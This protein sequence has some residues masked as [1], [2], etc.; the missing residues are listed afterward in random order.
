M[1]NEDKW[2][3]CN[4]CNAVVQLNSTGMCLGCQGG[5]VGRQEEDTYKP[6]EINLNPKGKI[7]PKKLKNKKNKEEIV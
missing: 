7:L 4:Y 6:E 3:V 5:F 1:A 2:M